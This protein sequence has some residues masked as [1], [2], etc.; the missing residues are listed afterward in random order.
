MT[1][2]FFDRLEA[3][4]AGRAR[5]GAHLDRAGRSGRRRAASLVRR[6]IVMVALAAVL[7]VSLASEFPGTATGRALPAATA[8]H[9]SL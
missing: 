3:E 2:S 1:D 8:I 6:S 5:Q 9:Q 7:A 4:L